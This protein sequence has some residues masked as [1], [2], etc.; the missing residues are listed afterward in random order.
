MRLLEKIAKYIIL[1]IHCRSTDYGDE[2]TWAAAWLYKATN[3]SQYLDEAEHHYMKFRLKERPNEF[4]YNKKVAGV[5]VRKFTCLRLVYATCAA[6]VSLKLLAFTT[7]ESNHFQVLLGQLTGKNE[8][9]DAAKAFCDFTV[10]Y[11]KRTPKG[12]VYIDKFGTLCHAANVA[13]VCLQV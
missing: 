1:S 10:H 9:L 2:L 4:F 3:E 6:Y 13:F 11:Q 5:Q 8:Y 12:L 7:F